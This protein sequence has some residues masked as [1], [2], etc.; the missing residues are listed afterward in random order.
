MD[1][2]N[3]IIK[4][5]QTGDQR[6]WQEI[7]DGHKYIVT[8]IVRKYFLVE[9]DTEDLIQEGM[10]GLCR[11][12]NTFDASR[13]VLFSTYA[14]NVVRNEIISAIRREQTCKGKMLKETVYGEIDEFSDDTTP[15]PEGDLINNENY[16]ELRC[17]IQKNLSSY[18]CSVIEYYLEGKSYLEIAKALGVDKK[19]IDNAITRI[20]NKL[21]R[22]IKEKK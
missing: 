10:K 19:S 8:S 22:A 20:K 2:I 11:A 13:D 6:A 17:L 18:E 4:S 1:N 12:V 5:A 9:E 3:D 16:Q 14:S 7:V 21:K 15:D